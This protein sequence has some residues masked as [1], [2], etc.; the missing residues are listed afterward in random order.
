LVN[1]LVK[2]QFFDPNDLSI[3]PVIGYSWWCLLPWCLPD[4]FAEEID[5]SWDEVFSR[6]LGLGQMGFHWRKWEDMGET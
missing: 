4:L 6:L 5:R 2:Q 1:L 3:A